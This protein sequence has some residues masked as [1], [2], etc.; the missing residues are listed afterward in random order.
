MLP[1]NMRNMANKV[2]EVPGKIISEASEK[3]LLMW[4]LSSKKQKQNYHILLNK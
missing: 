2:T 3:C 4:L 1:E